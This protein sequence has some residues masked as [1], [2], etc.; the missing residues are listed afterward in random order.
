MIYFQK[1]DFQAAL[2]GNKTL[3]NTDYSQLNTAILG[4]SIARLIF[5]VCLSIAPL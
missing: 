2:R 5:V 4:K 3:A 1:A